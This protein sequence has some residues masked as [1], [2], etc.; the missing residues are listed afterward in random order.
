MSVPSMCGVLV[1]VVACLLTV[2]VTASAAETACVGV[3]VVATFSSRTTLQVSADELLFNVTSAEA[4][5]VASVDFLAAARTHAG[6]PVVLSLEPIGSPDPDA[7]LSFSGQGEGTT[8]ATVGS[9]TS[10]IA[11]QWVGSGVRHGRLMFA[12][13]STTL[14]RH[15]VP[16][17]FVLSTP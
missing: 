17:R 12:L 5:A 1:G 10:T 16:V 6:G 11:G 14:G 15:A 7:S 8:S 13:R 4:P 2:S 9:V 3:T